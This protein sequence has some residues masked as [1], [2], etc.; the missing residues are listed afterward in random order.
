MRPLLFYRVGCNKALNY[1]G[2]PKFLCLLIS[3]P[4]STTGSSNFVTTIL[5]R[6]V[7]LFSNILDVDIHNKWRILHIGEK[8]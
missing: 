1:V 5:T 8:I 2:N 6:N 3:S 7:W 4:R